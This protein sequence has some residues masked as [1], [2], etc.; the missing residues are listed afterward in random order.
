MRFALLA[1]FG[2]S[3]LLSQAQFSISL[4]PDFDVCAN[5]SFTLMVNTNNGP[6]DSL[7]WYIQTYSKRDSLKETDSTLSINAFTYAASFVNRVTF[8]IQAFK[9]GIMKSDSMYVTV[10]PLP[11]IEF[12]D[13]IFCQDINEIHLSSELLK[14]PSPA[15]IN[16]GT[17]SWECVECNGNNFNNMLEDRSPTSIPNYWLNVDKAHYTLKNLTR[18]TVVLEFTFI[19][20]YGC[21]NVD[22]VS[23]EIWHAPEIWF[24]AGRDLCWSEGEID[25]NDLFDVNWVDGF[26]TT[27]DGWNL[28][29]AKEL[30][31]INDSS[32]IN[33]R[34]STP[35]TVQYPKAFGLRFN[36]RATGCWSY[37]D[38]TLVI[39][40]GQQSI[41]NPIDPFYCSSD[42]DITLLASPNWSNS[43]WSCNDTPAVENGIFKPNK[44]SKFNEDILI[45]YH[46]GVDPSTGCIGE[47]N[48]KT[49]VEPAPFVDILGQERHYY[50]SK[51]LD[52]LNVQLRYSAAHLLYPLTWNI[53]S[54]T[55]GAATFNS[56]DQDSVIIS[57][58]INSIDS[59]GRFLVSVSTGVGAFCPAADD[60]LFINIYVHP[61]SAKGIV[62][63]N[64]EL[65]PN[66]THDLLH[67]R[68]D[69][70]LIID[71][72]A[73][74]NLQGQTVI[75]QEFRGTLNT[76][77]VSMLEP[78]QY[79]LNL[80]SGP[81]IRRGKFQVR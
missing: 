7:K 41:I 77:D 33:T 57:I 10:N 55:G 12:K 52:T 56:I 3:A 16:L 78:G 67:L 76:I 49:K 53:V 71:R 62:E 40:N 8:V 26:W 74:L 1:L 17:P 25:L 31:G 68:R 21:K 44:A 18:D 11:Q 80:E 29:D 28:R 48:I 60:I 19:N 23:F 72:W 42:P 37:R 59:F 81:E 20:Q 47:F 61:L 73:I 32:L 51:S 64:L 34:N 54:L 65:F 5:D 30:G 39:Q 69:N 43:F 2:L 9:N 4:P 75:Q 70:P 45:T 36:H 27:R 14:R 58:P 13:K 15:G 24:S 35:S 50:V 66:P 22:T 38:T 6:A 46:S 63:S 79:I